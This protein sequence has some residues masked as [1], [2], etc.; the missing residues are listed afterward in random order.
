MHLNRWSP[1]YQ[2]D[3]TPSS[4]S[5]TTRHRLR[6][7]TG[8]LSTSCLPTANSL[9]STGAGR[10]PSQAVV[11]SANG[12]YHSASAR[13]LQLPSR[14]HLSNHRGHYQ[15]RRLL[16]ATMVVLEH[17]RQSLIRAPLRADISVASN[18][19][20]IPCPCSNKSLGRVDCPDPHTVAGQ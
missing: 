10:R 17:L 18:S 8:I 20:S 15:R 16:P 13:R 5:G 19:S 7:S 6:Y 9:S 12:R 11:Q 4:M 14:L 2:E 3:E 1:T